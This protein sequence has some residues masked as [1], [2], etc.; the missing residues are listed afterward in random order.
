MFQLKFTPDF[1]RQTETLLRQK[2]IPEV[3]LPQSMNQCLLGFSDVNSHELQADGT[4]WQ[5]SFRAVR[6]LVFKAAL[7]AL[8]SSACAASSTLA[9]MQLLKANHDLQSMWIFSIVYFAMNCMAQVAIFYSGRLRCWVGLGVEAHLVS[10][11]SRKLL[12][13]NAA[14]AARQ[15]SGNLKTLITSDVRN[16][17]QFMDNAVRNLLPSLAAVAVISPLLIVFTGVPGLFGLLVI[18]LAR[19]CDESCFTVKSARKKSV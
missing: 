13:L 19:L 3:S 14:A 15:S 5:E 6:P 12:R 4:L 2:T 8:F 1:G 17:G 10:R 18:A 11:I 7:I 16:V 9:A